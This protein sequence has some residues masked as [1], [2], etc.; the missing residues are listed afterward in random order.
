[1]IQLY[2]RP[3]TFLGLET[4]QGISISGI[5]S[6]INEIGIQQRKSFI[7]INNSVT[8]DSSFGKGRG[9]WD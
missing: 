1:M 2:M 5:K 4:S 3:M 8:D 6:S 7:V 9:V